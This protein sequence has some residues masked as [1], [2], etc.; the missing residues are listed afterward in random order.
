[1]VQSPCEICGEPTTSLRGVCQRTKDCR[2]EHRLRD[3]PPMERR[4]LLPCE[5]CGNPT[6]SALGVCA[7]N[8]VCKREHARRYESLRRPHERQP[9]TVCG[10]PTIAA[11][12]ICK[13]TSACRNARDALRR[14]PLPDIGLGPCD[15]CG[16]LTRSGYGVCQKT[17]P[18]SAEFTRRRVNADPEGVRRVRKQY[19]QRPDRPCRYAARGCIEF[20]DPGYISCRPH[21]LADLR[22]YGAQRRSRFTGKL[23]QRQG[24]ACPWC[25]R[26]LPTDLT[27]THVDHIIPV[28]AGGP[29]EDWNYQLLHR[30]CNLSKHITITPRAVALAAERGIV[31]LDTE[32]A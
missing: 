15:V 16:A 22:R 4:P 32:A 13:R 24:W 3:R 20:A 2:R 10:T 1:M 12:G 11:C 9:C 6:R 21:R 19:L 8:P 25:T 30:A 14:P 28:A 18:C 27:E 29:D 26:P 5:L 7:N 17:G 31:L 23:A